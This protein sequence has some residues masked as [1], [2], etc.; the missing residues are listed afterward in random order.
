[1]SGLW[2][3]FV[4][5]VWGGVSWLLWQPA[6]AYLADGAAPRLLRITVIAL[7]AS[8]WLGVSFWYGG[9]RKIYYDAEVNRLCAI[10]GGAKVYETVMLPANEYE[11]LVQKNWV[12]PDTKRAQP[13]DKYFVGSDTQYYRASDPQVARTITR[14]IRRSDG[15]VLGEYVRYGRGG[16]DIPGPWHGSSYLCPNPTTSS[17]FETKIFIKGE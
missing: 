2:L 12:L 3:L 9:G 5:V 1:M 7:A 4:L 17:G 11:K 8:L 6:R 15:K 16:G 14:V 10:D 13:I